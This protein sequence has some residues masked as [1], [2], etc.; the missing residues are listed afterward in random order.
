[1]LQQ[2]RNHPTDP[3]GLPH[4]FYQPFWDMIQALKQ[5]TTDQITVPSV[6]SRLLS[7]IHP[8]PS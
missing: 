8:A 1:M 4:A 3:K 6:R 5:I 2:T 7:Q